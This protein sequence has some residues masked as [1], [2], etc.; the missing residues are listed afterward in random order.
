MAS[1][2]APSGML[3]NP[4]SLHK[5][6]QHTFNILFPGLIFE[7]QCKLVIHRHHLVIVDIVEVPLRLLISRFCYGIDESCLKNFCDV[8]AVSFICCFVTSTVLNPSGGFVAV[9]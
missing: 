8:A 2:C 3:V 5:A 1:L 7:Y 9:F 4:G 6:R